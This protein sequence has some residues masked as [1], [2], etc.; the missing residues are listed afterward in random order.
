[1]RLTLKFRDFKIYLKLRSNKYKNFHLMTYRLRFLELPQK[2]KSRRLSLLNQLLKKDL[3]SK[4]MMM[5]HLFSRM[6]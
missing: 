4:P 1:M 5:L 6:P 2:I 3:K